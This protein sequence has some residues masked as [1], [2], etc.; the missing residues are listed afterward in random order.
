MENRKKDL[1]TKQKIDNI[2]RII[3]ILLEIID[4]SIPYKKFGFLP[5]GKISQIVEENKLFEDINLDE[6]LSKNNKLIDINE[7]NDT[8]TYYNILYNQF[9]SKIYEFTDKNTI[10]FNSFN[11]LYYYKKFIK[12]L[13]DLLQKYPNLI[14]DDIIKEKVFEIIH[15]L[16]SEDKLYS[17]DFYF[18]ISI[19]YIKNFYDKKDI[20]IPGFQKIKGINYENRY[21]EKIINEIIKEKTSVLETI[22]L[23]IKYQI[24]GSKLSEY[25]NNMIDENSDLK[26]LNEIKEQ[27]INIDKCN[28]NPDFLTLTEK[29][30]I[31][32]INENTSD[33]GVIKLNEALE[34]DEELNNIFKFYYKEK[35]DKFLSLEN[36][37]IYLIVNSYET[38]KKTKINLSFYQYNM[39]Y[40]SLLNSYEEGTKKEN[41]LYNI[42][43][44]IMESED[45]F[46]L[47]KE[48]YTSDIIVNYIKNP[49]Q[50]IRNI[51]TTKIEKYYEKDEEFKNVKNKLLEN[52]V[53]SKFTLKKKKDDNDKKIN[54]NN[55]FDDYLE[56]ENDIL[57]QNNYNDSKKYQCQLE[58]DYEYFMK[59]IFNENFFKERIIYSYLPCNIKGFVNNLPKIT[60]NVSGNSVITFRLDKNSEEYKTIIKALCVC[61]IIHELIHLCRRINKNKILD[62]IQFTPKENNNN[63]EGGRSLIYHIFEEFTV[64]YIDL[65]LANIIL[66]K[67]CWKNETKIFKDKYSHLGKGD[68]NKEKFVEENGGIKCYNS[69]IEDEIKNDINEI[70][71]F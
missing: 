35:M 46:E 17:S 15:C 21:I 4:I 50:Y 64:I 14:N 41:S 6:I 45:F 11:Q 20:I 52:K 57:N 51:N 47:I 30:F 53:V 27:F 62:N 66:D 31:N 39:D 49:I 26:F 33:I 1:S 2:F 58:L 16:Q 61:V 24:K 32:F 37:H 42:I 55:L 54:F 70:Y 68:N 48:I 23:L 59:N 38:E 9:L 60:I 69:A 67:Q 12:Y 36:E 3:N 63:Y 34:Y 44:E 43:K 25:F 56:G 13:S 18:Y 5:K 19:L 28:F 8:Q 71:C 40:I 65:D 22:I 7:F 10:L 29:K